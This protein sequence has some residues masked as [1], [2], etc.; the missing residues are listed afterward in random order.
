[1]S[2]SVADEHLVGGDAFGLHLIARR[3]HRQVLGH[4]AALGAD[5]HDHRILHLLR[6]HQA[7]NLGAEVLRPVGPADAAARHLAEAQMHALDARRIDGDLVERARQ[8]QVGDLAALELEG[9]HRLRL[10]FRV[11]LEEIRADRRLHDVD[12]MTQ[13]AVL[14]EAVHILQFLFDALDDCLLLGLAVLRRGG[15]RIETRV[16]QCDDVVD[17]HECLTSVAHMYSCE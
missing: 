11:G 2:S 10:T 12:E 4:E 15:A 3:P 5:R 1:M 6:L 7:E 13:D 17:D 8:R 9:D 14:V 16:E